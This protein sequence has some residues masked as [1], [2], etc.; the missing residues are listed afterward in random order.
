MKLKS[1]LDMVRQSHR[2]ENSEALHILL[3]SEMTDIME[4]TIPQ[5]PHQMTNIISNIQSTILLMIR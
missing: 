2:Q 5:N 4:I 3:E 1:M